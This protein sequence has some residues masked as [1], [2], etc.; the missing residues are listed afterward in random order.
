MGRIVDREY[1][2]SCLNQYFLDQEKNCYFCFEMRCRKVRILEHQ[3]CIKKF[4]SR[5]AHVKLWLIT[6][7]GPNNHIVIKPVM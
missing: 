3:L 5:N 2:A 7:I 4:S 1:I 6:Y